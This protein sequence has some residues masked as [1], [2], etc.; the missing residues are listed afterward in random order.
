MAFEHRQTMAEASLLLILCINHL[1][2]PCEAD[3][4]IRAEGWR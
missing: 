1:P 4:I 3:P 2:E